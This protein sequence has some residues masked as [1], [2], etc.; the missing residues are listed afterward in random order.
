MIFLNKCLFLKK[1]LIFNFIKCKCFFIVFNFN[2]HYLIFNKNIIFRK[3]MI[4]VTNIN[5]KKKINLYGIR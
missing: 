1:Y 2:F 3:K 4:C 5:F